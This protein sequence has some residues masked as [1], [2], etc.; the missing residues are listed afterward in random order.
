[1]F[2]INNKQTVAMSERGKFPQFAILL[3]Q[4]MPYLA[5]LMLGYILLN[6]GKFHRVPALLPLVVVSFVVSD[7]TIW[8]ILHHMS[9]VCM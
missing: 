5:T 4:W 3:A 6:F 1:M 7:L 2:K 8:M 9:K